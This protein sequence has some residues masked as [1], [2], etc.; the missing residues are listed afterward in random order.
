MSNPRTNIDGGNSAPSEKGKGP[1]IA[2]TNMSHSTVLVPPL[3]QFLLS[4]LLQTAGLVAA[5]AFGV[6]A[7]LSVKVAETGNDLTYNGTMYANKQAAEAS[8]LAT[9]ANRL[10]LLTLCLSNDLRIPDNS[11]AC[12]RVIDTATIIIPDLAAS[13]FPP[14]PTSQSTPSNPTE[15]GSG[16]S[17][18][19]GVIGITI[20]VVV[21]IIFLGGLLLFHRRIRSICQTHGKGRKVAQ[22][23]RALFM[24][25]RLITKEG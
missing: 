6:F 10:A 3:G 11:S 14:S 25:T 19:G 17:S 5:V 18:T 12:A 9:A 22:T 15:P 13:L 2:S 23:F 24:D 16:S 7:I 21:A 4:M 20:G 1:A 8:E